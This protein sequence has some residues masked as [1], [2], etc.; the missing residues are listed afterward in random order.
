MTI[1]NAIRNHNK[2]HDRTIQNIELSK[3]ASEIIE[4]M[5]KEITYLLR[6]V[7]WQERQ[8]QDIMNEEEEGIDYI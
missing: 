4:S 5:H 1:L 7:D 3:E 2:L 8:M 6:Y